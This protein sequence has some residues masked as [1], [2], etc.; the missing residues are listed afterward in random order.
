MQ[1]VDSPAAS[2]LASLT[3]AGMAVGAPSFLWGMARLGQYAP[4]GGLKFQLVPA[5]L[6]GVYEPVG[7]AGAGQQTSSPLGSLAADLLAAAADLD[8][9]ALPAL[10]QLLRT[11]LSE[12]EILH[13]CIQRLE[14]RPDVGPAS[15]QALALLGRLRDDVARLRSPHP[16]DPAALATTL[17][18]LLGDLRAENDRLRGSL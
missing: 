15:E 11:V 5:L 6:R 14:A 8:T 4:R 18:A 7:G 12:A 9:A 1:G 3:L 16:P 10:S 2:A 13:L 17:E